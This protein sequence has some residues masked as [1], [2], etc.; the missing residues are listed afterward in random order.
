MSVE[1]T[2]KNVAH[3]RLECI[4]LRRQY[5]ERSANTRMQVLPAQIA[6]PGFVSRFGP[7]EFNLG[8]SASQL[9]AGP[10]AEVWPSMLALFA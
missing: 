3:C 7:G 4:D 5:T 8:P 6:D 2:C 9:D 1:E 10:A